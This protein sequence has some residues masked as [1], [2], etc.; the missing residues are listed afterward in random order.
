V[1]ASNRLLLLTT[2]DIP[3]IKS[4]RLMLEV[5][6]AMGIEP[7]RY[8]L[9]ISQ[10]GRRYGVKVEDIERSLS[11]RALAAIP[12]DEA[13]PILAANQGR[14][15]YEMDPEAPLCR[16]VLGLAQA[17]TG[18]EAAAEEPPEERPRS[19]L[20]LPFLGRSLPLGNSSGG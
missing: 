9:V 20:R 7:E 3:S 2:P 6:D 15:L 11:M 16:A 4:S 14:P 19:R 5:L 12:Y 17:L 13:G 10:A 18:A 8:S 1:D